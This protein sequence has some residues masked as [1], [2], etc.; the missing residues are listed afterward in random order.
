MA[1]TCSKQLLLPS[2]TVPHS[3]LLG[4]AP[5]ATHWQ[6]VSAVGNSLKPDPGTA[7]FPPQTQVCGSRL[8]SVMAS[9]A[10][11][12]RLEYAFL[13]RSFLCPAL[14]RDPAADVW[15]RSMHAASRFQPCPMRGRLDCQLSDRKFRCRHSWRSSVAHNDLLDD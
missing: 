10:S 8:F 12:S 13:F 15:Q 3:A 7:H 11:C 4:H 14:G 2:G 9:L 5:E 6:N 1:R